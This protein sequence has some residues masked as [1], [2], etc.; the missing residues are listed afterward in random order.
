[1][2][3]YVLLLVLTVLLEALAILAIGVLVGSSTIKG[4][5]P[6][7]ICL[8]LVT[9]PLAAMA[10]GLIGIP[11]LPLEVTVTVIEGLGFWLLA[12]ARVPI[13]AAIAFIAN[14]VSFSVGVAATAF[15]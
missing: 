12:G 6:W 13:A 8:N 11:L 1:M 4:L 14:A 3:S 2:A 15:T 7:S 10:Y 9:H 5:V